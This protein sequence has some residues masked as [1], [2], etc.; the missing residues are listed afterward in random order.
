[1]LKRATPAGMKAIHSKNLQDNS[2]TMQSFSHYHQ[3]GRVLVEAGAVLMHI[4]ELTMH[5]P[6]LKQ[7]WS[8]VKKDPIVLQA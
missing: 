5:R 6:H 7:E 3:G 4:Q 8:A 2:R 1:M